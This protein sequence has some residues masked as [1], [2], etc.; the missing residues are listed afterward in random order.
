[1]KLECSLSVVKDIV[2]EVL[3]ETIISKKIS[4]STGIMYRLRSYL[5]QSTMTSIYYSLVYPYLNYCVQVWGGTYQCHLNRIEILQKRAIRIVNNAQFYSHTLPL[6]KLSRVLKF[7][8]VYKFNVA[9]YMYKNSSDDQFTRQH[10]YN[11]RGRANLLPGFQR[12]TLTQQSLS[13]RGPN[14]WN[15]IPQEIKDQPNIKLFKKYFKN[16]LLDSY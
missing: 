14:V 13:F 11:T 16:Y 2:S 9:V 10:S 8:D 6:F 4:R 3:Q 1:M 5:P 15:G 7:S 12:L